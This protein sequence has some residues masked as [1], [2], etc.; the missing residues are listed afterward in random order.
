MC[1]W[2]GLLK[3]LG[4]GRYPAR[5]PPGPICNEV[6]VGTT[7]QQQSVAILQDCPGIILSISCLTSGDPSRGEVVKVESEIIGP[8]NGYD[9]VWRLSICDVGDGDL[10]ARFLDIIYHEEVED[11]GDVTDTLYERMHQRHNLLELLLRIH[12][13]LASPPIATEDAGRYFPRRCELEH[14]NQERLGAINSYICKRRHK[15][16]FNTAREG[17]FEVE[18]ECWVC[19]SRG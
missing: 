11:G 5:L 9:R 12:N 19:V 7:L 6:L 18:A 4:F 16:L 8:K 15:Q 10:V 2:L 13:A 3:A 17:L 14:Y 1:P